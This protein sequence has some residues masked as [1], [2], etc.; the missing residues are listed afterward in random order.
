MNEVKVAWNALLRWPLPVE[1]EPRDQTRVLWAMPLVGLIVGLACWLLAGLLQLLIARTLLAG[2][3]GGVVIVFFYVW[4]M[5]GRRLKALAEAGTAW[6]VS[7]EKS[8]QPWLQ[9]V[10]R[11]PQILCMGWLLAMTAGVFGLIVYSGTIWLI[12]PPVLATTALAESSRRQSGAGEG[13][14]QYWLVA[15]LIV[16]PVGVALSRIAAAL[17]GLLAAWMVGSGSVRWSW[18]DNQDAEPWFVIALLEAAVLWIGL[19]VL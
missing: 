13:A 18:L 5:R 1:N 4:S 12:I 19:L 2:L 8:G 3:I 7:R 10:A 11:L 15:L 16:L 9:G 14:W 17:L 6:E